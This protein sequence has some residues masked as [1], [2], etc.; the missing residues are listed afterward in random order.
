[1]FY[2]AEHAFDG[3]ESTYWSSKKDTNATLY[4]SF[5]KPRII[6]KVTINF[7]Y[8]ATVGLFGAM[9]CKWGLEQGQKKFL[10]AV[11]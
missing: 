3:K 6:E 9:E 7:H 2:P 1:M 5:F 11:S 8:P 4:F 10:A